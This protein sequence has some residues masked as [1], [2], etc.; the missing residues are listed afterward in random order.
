MVT[1]RTIL[2]LPN[3]LLLRVFVSLATEDVKELGNVAATCRQFRNFVYVRTSC[4][5]CR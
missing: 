3:E 4:C 5:R 2:D 1:A